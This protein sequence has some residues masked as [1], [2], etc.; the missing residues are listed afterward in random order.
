MI[1]MPLSTLR[2]QADKGPTSDFPK[3]LFESVNPC[4]FSESHECPLPLVKS[5]QQSASD[6]VGA[7]FRW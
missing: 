1:V 3:L 4:M 2:K 6:S 5:F 7:G